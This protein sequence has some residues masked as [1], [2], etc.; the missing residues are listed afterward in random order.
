MKVTTDRFTCAV[1]VDSNLFKVTPFI[2]ATVAKV[3]MKHERIP[4]RQ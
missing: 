4:N 3:A 2:A 1:I